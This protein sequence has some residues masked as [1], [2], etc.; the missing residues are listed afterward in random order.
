MYSFDAS[1]KKLSHMGILCSYCLFVIVV[2]SS[3][4]SLTIMHT[5]FTKLLYSCS[6]VSDIFLS[7]LLYKLTFFPNLSTSIHTFLLFPLSLSVM[8]SKLYDIYWNYL[9]RFS[10]MIETIYYILEVTTCSS[11]GKLMMEW[12]FDEW[13]C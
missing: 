11:V 7:H 1:E 3:P 12:S 8:R 10:F 5:F 4:I 6:T 2:I 9:E 13:N